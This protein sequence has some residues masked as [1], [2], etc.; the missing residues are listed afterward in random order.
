MKMATI[1]SKVST[2]FLRIVVQKAFSSFISI[3]LAVIKRVL[4]EEQKKKIKSMH[5]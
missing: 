4:A 3:L 2:T 1:S 5:R